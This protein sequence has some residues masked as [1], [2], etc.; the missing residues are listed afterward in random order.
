MSASGGRIPCEPGRP[1][2]D[3]VAYPACP[4][5]LPTRKGEP[6]RGYMYDDGASMGCMHHCAP[7]IRWQ[8]VLFPRFDV[9]VGI[10]D[11][12]SAICTMHSLPFLDSFSCLFIYLFCSSWVRGR[13]QHS[14]NVKLFLQEVQH[15]TS[16]V[17]VQSLVFR[18][19][20]HIRLMY[21]V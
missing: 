1:G 16:V 9:C 17:S 6:E 2:Q 18:R 19:T 14:E 21:G 20:G 7:L 3:T 15:P 10:R 5:G 11:G 13:G 8:P 4:P 12:T